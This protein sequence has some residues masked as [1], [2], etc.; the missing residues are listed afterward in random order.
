MSGDDLNGDKDNECERENRRADQVTIGLVLAVVSPSQVMVTV[1]PPVSPKV[2]ARILMT[3][4]PR[5]TAGTLLTAAFAFIEN[6]GG[7]SKT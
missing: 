6:S 7:T 1:S 5:L 4:N 2:V 3:Q